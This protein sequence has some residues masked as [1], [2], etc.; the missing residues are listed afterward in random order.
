MKTKETPTPAVQRY[1]RAARVCET[2]QI[3]KSTLWHWVATRADFP[4]P[5]KAGPRVTLFDAQAIEAFIS[6]PGA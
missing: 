5:I 2:Y 4:K 3:A 6:R 1:M